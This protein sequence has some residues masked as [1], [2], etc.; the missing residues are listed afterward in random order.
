MANNKIV[1]GHHKTNALH[2]Y[3]FPTSK[4]GNIF[5]MYYLKS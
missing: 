2:N 4:D 3:N 1:Q 5:T